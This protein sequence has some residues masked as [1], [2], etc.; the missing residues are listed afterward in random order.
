MSVVSNNA[1]LLFFG[2]NYINKE[3]NLNTTQG[4]KPICVDCNGFNG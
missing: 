3:T 1:V 4:E 2:I